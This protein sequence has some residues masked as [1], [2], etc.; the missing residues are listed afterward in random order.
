MSSRRALTAAGV[1]LALAALLAPLALGGDLRRRAAQRC[2][3]QH[4]PAKMSVLPRLSLAD[5][6]ADSGQREE[7][8]AVLDVAGRDLKRFRGPR[9][10]LL[11]LELARLE[12]IAGR[13][14]RALAAWQRALAIDP[15]ARDWARGPDFAA[16]RAMLGGGA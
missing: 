6:L 14:Q 3:A 7:L 2:L 4:R 10:E 1:A 15:R 16:L 13:R 5:A 12:A 8:P 9:T 11:W